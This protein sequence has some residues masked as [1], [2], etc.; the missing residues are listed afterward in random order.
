MSARIIR[1]TSNIRPAEQGG[2]LTI[3]NFDGVH[4]GHQRL[5]ALTNER[6]RALGVP[7]VAMTFEPHGFEYFSQGAVTIP[8]LTRM[9]EKYLQLSACGMGNVLILPFN[10]QIADLSASEFVN[11][12]IHQGLRPRHIVVGD[13]FHF[14]KKR[15]GDITLLQ[16]MGQSLGFTVEALPTV[17]LD[18]ER[19]SST[20]IRQALAAG[21]HLLV[22]RLLGRPY[23]MMGRVRR[24][25][26]RGRQIGF[27]TANIFL[28]RKLT[29]VKG[30][31]VV[32]MRGL[33]QANPA[34]VWPGVANVGQR[35]TFDGTR[36]LL[37]V[38]LLDFNQDIYGRHVEVE[39]CA[40]VR[41]EEKYAS[42]D[43]LKE[44]IAK[45]VRFARDYFHKL[46]V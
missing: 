41:N 35:P 33:D 3:G 21:D 32:Y 4:L 29:P 6:A 45:D 1:S 39:F 20:R 7:S 27:P 11:Q 37:E 8:R 28:Q 38:H 46:G 2:V 22:N 5:L 23:S 14:G 34:K 15:Q 19:V 10:Q 24:G 17:L 30:V 18:G 9:R 31:Y 13:D 12:V 44:Q 43:A 36:T 16:R 40:K 25:D 26:Q 42:F